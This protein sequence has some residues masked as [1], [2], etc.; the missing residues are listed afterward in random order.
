MDS[1][2]RRGD[3]GVVALAALAVVLRPPLGNL[4]DSGFG[5]VHDTRLGDFHRAERFEGAT[6]R[7]AWFWFCFWLW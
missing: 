7:R 5:D 4:H 3:E 1:A 2:R 6:I